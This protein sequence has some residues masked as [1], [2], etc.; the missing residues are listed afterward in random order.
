MELI[1][2]HEYNLMD[3]L[4]EKPSDYNWG[5]ETAPFDMEVINFYLN[6][7]WEQTTGEQP[8]WHSVVNTPLNHPIVG[9]SLAGLLLL[10]GYGFFT[11]GSIVIF[12]ILNGGWSFYRNLYYCML[13]KNSNP[14]YTPPGSTTSMT[15]EP[16]PIPSLCNKGL[17]VTQPVA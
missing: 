7:L 8:F 13:R 2:S 15:Y 16:A 4:N 11:V 3:L 6:F 17:P 9:S 1:S 5:T 14:S 10:T 12:L